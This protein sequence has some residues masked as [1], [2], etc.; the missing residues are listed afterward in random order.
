MADLIS[1]FEMLKL[2]AR[3]MTLISAKSLITAQL[4]VSIGVEIAT[5][6]SRLL[7][8]GGGAMALQIKTNIIERA[9]LSVAVIGAG[10][11]FAALAFSLIWL[12]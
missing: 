7:K 4:S 8:Q 5:L 3:Y 9:F 6:R 12:N 1:S 2:I 11:L 10:V